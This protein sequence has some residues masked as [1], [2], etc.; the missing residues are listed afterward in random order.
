MGAISKVLRQG[1]SDGYKVLMFWCPGCQE[2]HPVPVER[3][4]EHPG[5]VWGWNGDAEKPVL[6]PSLLRTDVI[7]TEKGN[8]DF[9]AWHAAGCPDRKGAPF[10]STPRV[11][12]TFVGCNGAAP[13]QI[14]FLNDC[15]HHLAGQTVDMVEK[16]AD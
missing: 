10:E 14:I 2:A 1:G 15:T 8:A 9:E 11:C 3:S 13:G 4:A 12:H 7:F 5:P 16:W 6:T